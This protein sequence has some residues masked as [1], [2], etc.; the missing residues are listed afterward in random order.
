MA[1]GD[2]TAVHRFGE[3]DKFRLGLRVPNPAF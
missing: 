1:A 2:T 3:L